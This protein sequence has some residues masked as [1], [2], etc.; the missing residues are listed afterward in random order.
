MKNL[1]SY[2]Y[3]KNNYNKQLK[4][5]LFVKKLYEK[6]LNEIYKELNKSCNLKF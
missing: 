1:L 5:I 2:K 6:I 4:E 3:K